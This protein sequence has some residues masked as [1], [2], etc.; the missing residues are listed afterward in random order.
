M[1]EAE[2]HRAFMD[3]CGFRKMANLVDYISG[4]N[5]VVQLLG[6]PVGPGGRRCKVTLWGELHAQMFAC[7]PCVQRDGCWYLPLLFQYCDEPVTVLAES[8][9]PEECQTSIGFCGITHMTSLLTYTQVMFTQQKKETGPRGAYFQSGM[10]HQNVLGLSGTSAP[11]PAGDGT[12]R[13]V[14]YYQSDLRRFP[15]H[16][17]QWDDLKERFQ[18]AMFLFVQ[19]TIPPGQSDQLEVAYWMLMRKLGTTAAAVWDAVKPF[20]IALAETALPGLPGLRERVLRVLQTPNP[21][22][23]ITYE[24]VRTKGSSDMNVL[25]LIVKLF[26]PLMDIK[27]IVDIE[28]EA[29]SV[30]IVH[31]VMGAYHIVN[32]R[33][34][35]EGLGFDV[36]LDVADN[37]VTCF[38]PARR[39]F[40]RDEQPTPATTGA[41]RTVVFAPD[42]PHLIEAVLS[43]LVWSH[44]PR[45]SEDFVNLVVTPP[46]SALQRRPSD[47]NIYV[48][49]VTIQ[50]PA[51]LSH[52][53]DP[54][55]TLAHWVRGNDWYMEWEWNT[56]SAKTIDMILAVRAVDLPSIGV[57][58]LKEFAK[59]LLVVDIP[60]AE[61]LVDVAYAVADW[62]PPGLDGLSQ[63][64]IG[65]R[66]T[67]EKYADAICQMLSPVVA[68]VAARTAKTQAR[69]VRVWSDAVH[70]AEIVAVLVAMG[71][72]VTEERPGTP[73]IGEDP[74]PD[75]S[76]EESWPGLDTPLF[77]D[78][79]PENPVAHRSHRDIHDEG[80][81]KM[82]AT[83][84]GSATEDWPEFDELSDPEEPLT[85]PRKKQRGDLVG[86]T[87]PVMWRREVDWDQ[88]H[89]CATWP[90]VRAPSLDSD[91]DVFDLGDDDEDTGASS[92]EN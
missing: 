56:Q 2:N 64:V 82:V 51:E 69:D 71:L 17:W 66:F 68:I 22:F 4:A 16:Q 88:Q 34:V 25:E 85:H 31:A 6:P 55:I 43:P 52:R 20:T 65:P 59:Q 42:G 3:H 48:A 87:T 49:L 15:L 32:V 19:S 86:A 27:M 54:L 63:L 11:A 67:S 18:Q 57:E 76:Y 28:R 79:P 89:P 92:P 44:T 14:T 77:P 7:E 5:R 90:P 47:T 53:L 81:N 9:D 91:D 21:D 8:S 84:K 58:E 45:P 74:N 72:Q 1:S 50:R 78:E 35:L 33:H 73:N 60:D 39:T 36:V 38:S 12:W 24:K 41:G 46:P 23:A 70:H 30:P 29:A 80:W 10:A 61:R 37:I 13:H 26:T 40:D 62:R 83:V 75:A